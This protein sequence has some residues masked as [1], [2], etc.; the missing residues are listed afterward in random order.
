MNHENRDRSSAAL[1]QQFQ[2]MKYK[3]KNMTINKE[4][5]HTH[6]H[7]SL[8]IPII[9]KVLS[10]CKQS[11]P[12]KRDT[13]T[14][15]TNPLYDKECKETKRSLKEGKFNKENKRKYEKLVQ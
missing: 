13:S 4:N 12:R 6:V 7:S 2:E 5:E 15:P 11:R 9:H 1:K 10:A 8:L 14:F 3:R